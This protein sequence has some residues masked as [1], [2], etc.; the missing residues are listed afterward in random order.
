MK[1]KSNQKF[2][3]AKKVHANFKIE[4]TFKINTDT[5]QPKL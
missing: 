4:N 5:H 1:K 3:V 2:H